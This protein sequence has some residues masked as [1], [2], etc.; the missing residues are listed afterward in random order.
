M[1]ADPTMACLMPPPVSPKVAC[2][3][4]NRSPLSAGIA[5]WTTLM[6]TIASTATAPNAASAAVTCAARFQSRR[7]QARP[8]AFSDGGMLA[9]STSVPLDRV[10]ADDH[11]SSEV[12]H[13]GHHEQDHAQVEKRAD[14]QVGHGALI[15][16]GDPARERVTSLEQ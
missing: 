8:R 2:T 15:L 11:L 10:A 3:C 9:A 1:I 12:R 6:T 13:Q 7:L 14:L 5:R 4:V 16:R